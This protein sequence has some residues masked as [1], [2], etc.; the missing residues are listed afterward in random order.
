MEAGV[1][2]SFI[3]QDAATGNNTNRRYES[4]GLAELLL[5]L[6]IVLF[7]ASVAL[8][9]ATFLYSQYLNQQH[10]QK[11]AQLKAAKEAFDPQLVAQ[12]T[13]LD[14]R[15]HAAETILAT[16]LA[17][18]AFFSTLNLATLKT[19]SFQ[20][21]VFDTNDL[22]HITLKMGGVA[23]SVN[24]IA[25]QADIFSKSGVI[26][27]PIFSNIGRSEDGVRFSLSAF[28]NPAT[29]NYSALTASGGVAASPDVS[30]AAG[31][32]SGVPTPV[33]PSVTSNQQQTAPS[34]PSTQT[35]APPIPS[36]STNKQN[37]ASGG[38]TI[39][40]TLPGPSTQT[41]APSNGTTRA[42][43]APAT[44]TTSANTKAPV[45]PKP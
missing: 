38:K 3:P 27:N 10:N 33:D 42:P 6:V 23:R 15:M 30:G 11:V 39:A 13:R 12:F 45:I 21:L 29:L 31:Q 2:T 44:A 43:V 40:P 17:P 25:L 14:D 35:V 4:G 9:I 5:L 37:A 34:N 16:H 41:T 19:I 20:T 22:N 7:V 26:T 36:I 1:P 32:N 8:A 18:T 28:I 24:S